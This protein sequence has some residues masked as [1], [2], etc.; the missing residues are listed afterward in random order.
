VP[1]YPAADDLWVPITSSTSCD[2]AIFVD[3]AADGSVSSDAELIGI[4]V[5]ALIVSTCSPP[6][7]NTAGPAVMV[8][9]AGRDLVNPDLAVKPVRGSAW[10]AG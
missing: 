3:R 2:Q 6:P 1:F 9:V 5:L 8:T 7:P 4:P 10:V